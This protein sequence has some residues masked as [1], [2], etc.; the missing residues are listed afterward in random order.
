MIPFFS[1]VIPAYNVEKYIRRTID[2]VLH[3]SFQ[4]YEIIIVN[5]GSVDNT[6]DIID[7]YAK[8][9][10]KIIVVTHLK[11]ES[12]HIAR[13]DGVAVSNGL[14][15]VF[16]D[17]D[18]Y[19]TVNSLIVLYDEINKN[20]G[21]D[22]YEYGYIEQPQGKVILPSFTRKDRFNSYFSMDKYPM[23][24][25]WNKVYDS[26]L[27]KKAFESLERVYINNTEDTYESVVISYYARNV[28]IIKKI[29]INYSIGTGVSTT[30]KDY[31]KTIDF[32]LCIK[33]IIIHIQNF[34]EKENQDISLDNLNY[35]FL[36]N[37]IKWYIVTQKNIKEK[38]ELFSK[39]PDFFDIKIIMKYLFNREEL[40]YKTDNIIKSKDYWLGNKIL[41]PLRKIKRLIRC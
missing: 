31:N 8:V 13:L 19:F 33:K 26:V 24:T 23:P 15:V 27:I 11:N 9:N 20:P 18:D 25:M 30:Y 21:Y 5:D 34:L 14:Y 10:E 35:R 1:I 28:Y 6:A 3:Q 12:L 40:Y 7:E 16:I 36:S 32:L 41:Y 4:D 22:F 29:I 37:T 2:S 17:G 39:L 38:E